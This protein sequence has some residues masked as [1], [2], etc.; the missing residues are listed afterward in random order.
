[1]NICFSKV[2]LH[3]TAFCLVFKSV[4]AN[5]MCVDL[6]RSHTDSVARLLHAT[7]QTRNLIKLRGNQKTKI[8]GPTGTLKL[9]PG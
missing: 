8:V 5:W 2:R 9:L 1:M 7:K 6:C 3:A 4:A